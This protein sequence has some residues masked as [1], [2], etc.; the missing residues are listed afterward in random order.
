MA[1]S[2]VAQE[3]VSIG[4]GFWFGH[5]CEAPGDGEQRRSLFLGRG[6]SSSSRQGAVGDTHLTLC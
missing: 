6:T 1:A 4:A 2:K 3:R 5:V